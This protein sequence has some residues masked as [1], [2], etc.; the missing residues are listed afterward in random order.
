MA[1]SN[2]PKQ[3]IQRRGRILRINTQTNKHHAKIYDILVSPPIPSE[4]A[5]IDLNDK[6]MI[7]KELLRHKEFADISE[8]RINAFFKIKEVAEKFEIDLDKLD[9]DYINNLR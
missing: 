5:H 9:Q 6:K 3:F 7:A 8:N 2:N 1:S 4:N